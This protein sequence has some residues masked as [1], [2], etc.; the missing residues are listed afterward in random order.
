MRPIRIAA[1]LHPQHGDYA[2]FRRAVLRAEVLGFDIVYTWDHFFP[3][4]GRLDDA[5]FECW[6]LLA[7]AAEATSGSSSVRSWPVTRIA[8]RTS[9]P[10]SPARSITSAAVE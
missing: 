7:A 1:Q 9:S 5:H 3:L 4:Y 6:S 2:G 10:T 8:T